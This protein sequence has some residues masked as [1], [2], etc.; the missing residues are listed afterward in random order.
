M[1]LIDGMLGECGSEAIRLSKELESSRESLRRTETTLQTI[2]NTHAAQMSQLEV[3]VSDLERD[4]GKTASSLLRV[5]KEKKSKSSE[6]RRLLQKIQTHEEMGARKSAEVADV[7]DGFCGR[8]TR[9]AALLE[10]LTDAHTRD[11]ALARIEGG[12]SELLLLRG[13]KA[14]SLD[15]E[16]ARLS[17][18]KGERTISEGDFGS[19]LASLQA[20]C[21]LAP[22]SEDSDGQESAR[23]DREAGVDEAGGDGAA[24]GGGGEAVPVASE[25]EDEGDAP[26]SV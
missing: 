10:S 13:D 19:I 14:P 12:L 16:E 22:S 4:L 7:R 20:E 26:E 6:V 9:I 2:E 18:C 3:R 11:V 15:S 23:E 24:E 21:T 5:K 25:F 8:L 1:S 17:S